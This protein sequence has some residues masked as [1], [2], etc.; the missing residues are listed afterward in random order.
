MKKGAGDQ[1]Q[2]SPRLDILRRLQRL[3]KVRQM[4]SNRQRNA[5]TNQI[6]KVAHR[7]NI[8]IQRTGK[9]LA[10]LWVPENHDAGNNV[11]DIRWDEVCCEMCDL[12]SLA[13]YRY[14]M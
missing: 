11:A 14:K 9:R 12:C 10:L 6:P 5:F 4:R 8:T 7:Q 1:L 3:R 2:S 13:I